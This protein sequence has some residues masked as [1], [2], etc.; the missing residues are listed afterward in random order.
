[1][2]MTQWRFRITNTWN[3]IWMW[4]VLF[5]SCLFPCSV[6]SV[7]APFRCLRTQWTCPVATSSAE[8]A[9]KG[10]NPPLC[11]LVQCVQTCLLQFSCVCVSQVPQCKDSGGWCSQYLLS[12]L[13]VLP[14][15]A[16]ACDRE[17]GFQGDG[18]AISSVWHQGRNTTQRNNELKLYFWLL[19]YLVSLLLAR[20][21]ATY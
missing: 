17:R 13:W 15:G 1:M 12:C 6:E 2:K 11:V 21:L 9:G 14:A 20:L 10:R 7:C 16:G 8:P 19:I 5:L 3:I 4:F 18:P